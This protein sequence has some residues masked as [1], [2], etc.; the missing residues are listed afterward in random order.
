MENRR[1][2]RVINVLGEEAL[3]KL[4]KASVMV[5][6]L[7]GVGSFSCEALVRSGVG[8]I[9]IVD[10]DKVDESNLNR[11]LEASE[12]TIGMLKTKAIAE[13]MLLI[14]P[15]V[16]IVE[17]AMFVNSENINEVFSDS[18]DFVIDAIDNMEGKLAIWQYCQENNIDLIASLGMAR[19]MD[20]T[21]IKV[22]TLNK[23]ENDPMARKLRYLARKR[24]LDLHIPVVCS[25]EDALP[26]GEDGVLGSM[27]FTP[28]TAGLICGQQCIIN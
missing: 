9:I 15:D 2:E 27:I 21:K 6:G 20:P 12:E 18:V 22:T 10:F 16:K 1:F 25:T 11:Q 13:R 28:A 3:N 19:R 26:M 5:I 17:K 23:T 4:Q 8:K 14:N 24:N 7:G